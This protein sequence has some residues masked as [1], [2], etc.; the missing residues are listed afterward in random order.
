MDRETAKCSSLIAVLL[1]I[2]TKMALLIL[3]TSGLLIKIATLEASTSC[4]KWNIFGMTGSKR[5]ESTQNIV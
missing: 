3:S 5:M 4:L 2:K 1:K